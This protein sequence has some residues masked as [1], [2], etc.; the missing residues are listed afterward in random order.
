MQQFEIK[1]SDFDPNDIIFNENGIN[2]TFMPDLKLKLNNEKSNIDQMQDYIWRKNIVE[3]HSWHLRRS[4]KKMYKDDPDIGEYVTNVSRSWLKLYEIVH[5]FGIFSM[6]TSMSSIKTFHNAEFPGNF[7]L[8]FL[9]MREK[10]HKLGNNVPDIDWVASSFID[11]DYK[12]SNKSSSSS[13]TSTILD[14][15]FGFYSRTKDNWLM[16]DINNG[17]M[18]N[19]ENINEIAARLGK[20]IDLYTHDAG[21]DVSHNYNNQ[22]KENAILHLGCALMGFKVLKNGGIFIGKQYT[23]FEYYTVD[24]M[25]IYSTLFD[26]FYITKPSTSGILNSEIYLIGIGFKGLPESTEKLLTHV[27]QS[28]RINKILKEESKYLSA[29]MDIELAGN[30]I[31]QRL[32]LIKYFYLDVKFLCS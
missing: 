30:K 16:N 20:T 13:S 3:T 2:N 18:T 12:N 8:S 9:F 25:M 10:L 14:D 7:I 27:F 17:D 4:I 22:E 28:R 23:F 21:I 26:K 6:F 1:V 24:L 11:T 19:L 32:S 15:Q 29:R 31:F 5:H